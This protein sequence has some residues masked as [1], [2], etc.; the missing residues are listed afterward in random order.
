MVDKLVVQTQDTV[1][2]LKQATGD[3]YKDNL[4]K[5]TGFIQDANN[6]KQVREFILYSKM[7][8]QGTR[9]S[10]CCM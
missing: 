9:L 4:D 5:A 8:W 10:N 6:S 1:N 2:I 3:I 7:S